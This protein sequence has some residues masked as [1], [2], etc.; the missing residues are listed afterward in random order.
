MFLSSLIGW[1]SGLSWKIRYGLAGVFILLGGFGVLAAWS[2][3]RTPP[4]I[5]F[6]LLIFGCCF[7]VFGGRSS[8]EKKGYRF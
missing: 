3:E 5:A 2:A 8:S 6:I 7:A 1:Y 4:G